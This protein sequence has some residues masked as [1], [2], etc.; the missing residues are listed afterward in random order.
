MLHYKKYFLGDDREWVVF[1]HGAG[2]SSSIWFKQIRSYQPHFNL[3]LIDLRGHGGSAHLTDQMKSKD[4]S[5]S[6]IAKDVL[7]TMDEVGVKQAHFV[8]VSLGTIIIRQLADMAKERV[9]SM[10]LVG[11][12]TYLNFKSRF[13]V[14][15]GR[16]FKNYMP[17]M[18]LYRIFAFVILPANNHSESRS[19]F[20][21]EAQKLCQREFLRW[22]KLTSQL[23]SLLKRLES[24]DNQIPTL[25][26]MGEEDH[27]FL[28]PIFNLVKSVKKSAL[29]IVKKC[30]HVV[31]I[32]QAHIFNDLSIDFLRAPLTF[33]DNLTPSDTGHQNIKV[34]EGSSTR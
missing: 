13:W 25:Y 33:L 16:V 21:E 24:N 7:I 9:S 15:I 19:V 32:E 2:G 29:F 22:F 20:I 23:T 5:F 26:V 10:V 11:A 4:Y 1:I 17:Y 6:N 34:Y 30:G 31:N 18:W 3:L 14:G 12:I 8:G 27:M 28:Q